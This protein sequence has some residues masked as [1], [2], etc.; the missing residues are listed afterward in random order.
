MEYG[1]LTKRNHL[2]FILLGLVLLLASCSARPPTGP[3]ETGRVTNHTVCALPADQ[4]NASFQGAWVGLP[5]T[6]VIDRDFY[7]T[8]Q[9]AQATQIRNAIN[10]WNDT[11]ARLRGFTAF[12]I[13]NDGS[14]LSAGA[15][16]PATTDCSHGTITNARTDV[17]GIWKIQA[18]G[19]GKNTRIDGAGKP[20]KLLPDGI[21]GYTDWSLASGKIIGASVLLNFDEFNTSTAKTLDVHS[22]ALHELGHVLGLLHSCKSDDSDL[23]SAP[24][25]SVAPQRYLEAV[26]FPF[27]RIN[28][29]RRS[30]QQN[31]YG[32]INCIY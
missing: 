28:Q 25:C 14:G 3:S 10:T 27:L 4:G 31:D 20:C 22:L 24:N 15:G 13:Q 17:V 32:R 19:D 21:Q 18:G 6:V 29:I 26:M 16:I 2:L 7:L 23:S 5:I 30:L 8:D 11:W 9:G 1:R 12:T